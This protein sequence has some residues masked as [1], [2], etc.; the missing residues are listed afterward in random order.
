MNPAMI[1][2]ILQT[3][4]SVGGALT[5]KSG[6]KKVS[7]YDPAQKRVYGQYEQAL[8]G[9]PETDQVMKLLRGY[10]DPN[11]EQYKDFEA[12]YMTQFNEQIVPGIAERFAGAGAQGGALSSS[13]FGQALGGAGAQLQSN[14]AG[15]KENIRRQ[16]ISDI[17]QQYQNKLG[18]YSNF[19][20]QQPFSYMDQGPGMFSNMLTKLGGMPNPFGAPKLGGG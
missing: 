11:S 7:N 17:L 8:Q 19:L 13:G 2:A 6:Y 9:T 3:L 1:M 18:N 20:G 16:S 14:L 15:M 10:L 4:S 12:P 5:D